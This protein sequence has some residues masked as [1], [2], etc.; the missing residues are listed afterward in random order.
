MLKKKRHPVIAI[1]SFALFF[2]AIF[3]Y[4]CGIDISIGHAYPF[5]ILAVLTA[6]SVF[7]KISHAAVAGLIS[8]AFIDSVSTGS[9]CFNSIMLLI[10]S[11]GACLLSANVFNK[12]VKAVTTLCFLS[13]V[14]YYVFYWLVFIVFSL[15]GNEN[16]EYLLDYALPSALYT[17]IFVI[18]LYFLYKYW[19]KIRNN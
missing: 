8:G 1:L 19:N 6:Y 17:A 12:N 18:P 14:V 16:M 2:F 9:Y 3:F 15:K 4:G 10:L 7:T 5:I 13:T 11:V